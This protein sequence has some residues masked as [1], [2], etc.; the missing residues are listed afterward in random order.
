MKKIRESLL[1]AGCL[2]LLLGGTYAVANSN[3]TVKDSNQSLD[4]LFGEL[5]QK[6]H[7]ADDRN[8]AKVVAQGK[9]IQITQR[10]FLQYKA[11]K[12]LIAAWN[13]L[14]TTP[15]NEE[16]LAELAQEKLAVAQ[17]TKRG[18]TALDEEVKAFISEQRDVLAHE[19]SGDVK[20]EVQ[21]VQQHLY[22]IRGLSEDAY[23]RDPEVVQN[24]K[25]LLLTQKLVE[26]LFAAGELNEADF[27]FED[28]KV[29][30]WQNVKGSI[31]VNLQALNAL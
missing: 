4:Q 26:E 16:L 28:Y 17:A 30:L 29:K 15:S 13:N 9:G 8:G 19:L 12:E 5:K 14:Q 3:S 18:I 25:D 11:N 23:W 1:L 31:K 21:K 24:Y 6:M 10:E 20:D 2:A 27:S 7:H 22:D